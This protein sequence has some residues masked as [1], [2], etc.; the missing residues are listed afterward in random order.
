MSAGALI[1]GDIGVV[2][3]NIVVPDDVGVAGYQDAVAGGQATVAIEVLSADGVSRDPPL[4]S[5]RCA[6]KNAVAFVLGNLVCS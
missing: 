4:V 2:E 5:A 3:V 6:E 1:A